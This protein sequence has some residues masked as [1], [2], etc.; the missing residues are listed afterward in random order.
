MLKLAFATTSTFRTL[1]KYLVIV[2]N[3]RKKDLSELVVQLIE[4][5]I[6]TFDMSK[7]HFE[8][9]HFPLQ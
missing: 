5:A 6:N 9:Y 7:V 1:I 3:F 2:L 4:F 8:S